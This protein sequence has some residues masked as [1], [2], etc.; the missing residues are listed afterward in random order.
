MPVRSSESNHQTL[1]SRSDGRRLARD[2]VP[3]WR[4]MAIRPG[5]TVEGTDN[6][7]V[8]SG[9]RW[10]LDIEP[11]TSWLA[12]F[13]CPCGTGSVGKHRTS[14]IEHRTSN[15][16]RITRRENHSVF[17]VGRW[18]LDVP[19]VVADPAAACRIVRECRVPGESSLRH[20]GW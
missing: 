14:N 6:P 7:N 19:N 9:R 8:P 16:E 1:L 5:G 12:N 4:G 20:D 2:E 11:A 18:L 17:N 3:G 13:R 10:F 15:V